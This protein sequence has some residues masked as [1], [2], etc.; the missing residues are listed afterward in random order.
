MGKRVFMFPGQGSQY[1]GMGKDFYENF[2]TAK[3]VFDKASEITGLDVASLCFE[4][5]EK[6]NITEYTQVCM[7]TVEA[8]LF[9][10]LK[11]KGITYDLTAGLSLGEYGALIASGA[12]SMEDAFAVVRKR[13]IY[14]QNAVPEGGA[15]SAVLGLDA[16]T[17][18]DACK[19]VM[20][21]KEMYDK[22]DS[23]LPFTVSVA[24]Y[25]NPKQSVI[26]GRKDAVKAAGDILTAKGALKVVE[27]NVSGPFHSAL[28]KGAGEQLAEALKDVELKD[29]EV[30]YIANVT[31]EYVKDKSEIKELLKE[32]VSSSVKWQQSLELMIKDGVD[33]F[34]EIGPGNTLSGFV[35]KIDRGLK[36]VNIDTLE[37]FNKFIEA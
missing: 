22:S 28:L 37:D 29:I 19:E 21:N 3:E 17:I 34:I 35:K 30:P 6:I 9:A 31:A 13:G 33:E 10:V 8:A 2:P 4:E 14:M 7:L 32:Q 36:T 18:E 16:A 26:T 25:N 23:S 5:N 24:N 1:I 27:L 12:M 20:D 15:M 11:E